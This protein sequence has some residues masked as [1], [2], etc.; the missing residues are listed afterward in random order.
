MAY[1][2][3]DLDALQK[4]L[5]RGVRRVSYSDRT[6]EFA[7]TDELRKAISDVQA[8][9]SASATTGA[10]KLRVTRIVTGKGF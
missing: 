5:A 8:G 9:L 6:V 7:S 10:K 1:T 2:Q 4:A 3:A